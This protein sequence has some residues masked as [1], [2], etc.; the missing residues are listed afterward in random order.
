MSSLLELQDVTKIY[1][2][3]LFSKSRT[4]ALDNVSFAIPSESP[5]ITA[6]AGESGSGKTTL[7]R[8][9]LGVCGAI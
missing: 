5:Q 1:G 7:A 9:L 4:L 8:G 6:I 3:G 2:G